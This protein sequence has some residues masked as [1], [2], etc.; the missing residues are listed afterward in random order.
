MGK[1]R[2][3]LVFLFVWAALGQQH[4][5]G[6]PAPG[7]A[8][9]LNGL[10]HWHHAITT[11]NPL[12][13]RYFDQGLTLVYAFNH[14]EAARSFSYAAKL[15]PKCAMA[16]WGIA[17]ARGPNYNEAEIDASRE[18]MAADA[19]K[20]AQAL[21]ANSSAGEQAYIRAMALRVSA[22]PKASQKM[23][24]ANYRDAMRAVM[25]TYPNDLDAAVLFADAAM[26]LH[27]WMLWRLDGKPEDGTMEAVEALESVLH[28]DPDNI[29]ANHFYIHVIEE[30]PHPEKAMA[31]ARKMADLAP[32]AGHLVHMPAHI[33]IRTGD[34]HAASI[35][36]KQAMGAD[37][38]Y[39]EKYHVATMYSMMYYTH[40]M[41]FLAVSSSMEG[42]FA[43]SNRVAARITRG[44]SPFLKEHPEVQSF[45]PTQMLVLVR[46]RRW[47]EIESFP[48]PDKSLD[49]AHALWHFARGMAFS[50]TGKLERAAGEREMF[51]AAVKAI[52][53]KEDFGYNTARQVFEIPALMLDANIARAKSDYRSAASLLAK[54][55]LAEDALN[56]DEPPDWYLPPRESLGAVLL[57]Q[58]RAPEA[59][60]AFREE[61]KQHAKNPRA[62]FGLA[63][64]LHAQ[65]KASEE[66]T[67]R[68]EFDAGWKHA[69][70]QLR[71]A[72]L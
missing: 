59:E 35:S 8:P 53:A 60:A 30:S 56:Y 24:A 40:N 10:G 52:P 41:H 2:T 28:R 54:A 16:Y 61:L 33:Y 45:L 19:V 44:I 68:K 71:I 46:F 26:E 6:A 50:S 7:A 14:D 69:D 27:A 29:G 39:I 20:K 34:Y 47:V 66:G 42:N 51:D 5:H 36:N 13:Q 49:Q 31:S 63:Q 23:L 64:C 22:D 62:L 1:F 32:G 37:Q 11:S 17:L 15:D 4:E 9:L 38:G 72:D 18:K 67:V 43:D 12:A 3:G 57:L 48:E 21:A 65:G 58:G 55:A 70:T 25:K